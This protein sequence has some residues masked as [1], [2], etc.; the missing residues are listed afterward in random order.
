MR[1][2]LSI[3]SFIIVL[4]LLRLA[5]R[6]LIKKEVVHPLYYV[7][8]IIALLSLLWSA[9]YGVMYAT[10]IKEIAS[11]AYK[12]GAIGWTFGLSVW[13]IF[14]V[15]LYNSTQKKKRNI[16]SYI[17]V[18]SIGFLFWLTA[19]DGKIFASDFK[20]VAWWGWEEI[21]SK[22]VLWIYLFG[23]FFAVTFIFCVV[24]V[25]KTIRRITSR[26]QTRLLKLIVF[27]FILIAIPAVAIN[28]IVPFYDPLI[29]PPVA[30]LIVNGFIL[31]LGRVLLEN[32]IVDINPMIAAPQMFFDI[33]DYVILTDIDGH[34]K[35]M[36][37][38]AGTILNYTQKDFERLDVS[39]IIP[40]LSIEDI[41]LMGGGTGPAF[42]TDV[43]SANKVSIPVRCKIT[44]V[45]DR[46][47]D[48]I[49]YLIIMSD[50]RD[51][52]TIEDLE[53]AVE[54]RTSE[55]A[56]KNRILSLEIAGREKIQN[57]LTQA[58][59][60]LK[61]MIAN[62]S[63][64][65]AIIDEDG[66]LIY[67][68]PNI[69]TF[70]GWNP[71]A[72]I[73]SKVL[74]AINPADLIKIK[75]IFIGLKR[76]PDKTITEVFRLR[77]KDGTYKHVRLTAINKIHNSLIEGILI[78]FYDVS[79]QIALEEESASRIKRIQSHQNA[80]LGIS[81][82]PFVRMGEREEAFRQITEAAAE[83][84]NADKVSIWLFLENGGNAECADLFDR[85]EFS[86]SAG[87]VVA[88]STYKG[89]CGR[90]ENEL[91]DAIEDLTSDER[92]G[93]FRSAAAFTE[94]S[95]AF[96]SAGIRHSG[97]LIGFI[98]FIQKNEPRKWTEDE[99]SFASQLA[100]LV[101]QAVLYG[102]RKAMESKLRLFANTVKSVTE[103][104]SIT[105]MEDRI[106]FVNEFFCRT[107]GYTEEELL[108]KT[109]N[110]L[111]SD[112][113]DVENVSEILPDTLRGKWE[114][115]LWNRKKD[116]TD[117]LIHLSTS[118]IKDESDN[119]VAL[120]GVATDITEKKLEEERL[121]SLLR[122]QSEMIDT[123]AMW[124]NTLDMEG[125]ITFWNKAAEKISGYTKEEVIF[126][127]QIWGM[128]Y[129]D[130]VY[131]NEVFGEAN[132]ILNENKRVEGFYTTIIRKDGEKRIIS[133]YSNSLFDERGNTVGS[134]AIGIDNTE[135]V[136]AEETLR[137]N[138][139][140]YRILLD[141][142]TDPIFSFAQDGTYL[143]ANRAFVSGVGK[144]VSEVIGKRIWDVFE[145]EEADKRYAA[146]K[147]V[148]ETGREKT[149][150][151]RVPLNGEDH[152]YITSITPIKNEAEK[153]TTVIC[154]SKE[155][156]D[157]K[158]TEDALRLSEQKMRLHI[159]ETPLGVI[160]W[161][162]EF[163][164]VSW[165]KA[166][167]RIFGYKAEEALGMNAGLLV[168]E[169]KKEEVRK[170][171]S[172]LIE[173]KINAK[174]EIENIRKDGG[175]I[176]CEW[177]N[178][179][180]TASG[181]DVIGVASLVLDITERQK[182]EEEQKRLFSELK[183]SRAQ[184]EEEAV[185]LALLN[186]QLLESEEKLKE[187]NASKDRFFSIIAHDLKSPFLSLLGYSEILSDEYDTLSE[188]ER[189]ESIAGIYQLSSNSYK[190]LENLLQWARIQIG[191]I[192]FA[193]EKFNLLYE[194]S[195][196]LL[197][198]GQTARDKNIIIDNVIERNTFLTADK[199]MI[200]SIIR[201]L[202]SN[203]IKFCNRGGHIVIS[204]AELDGFTE[205]IIKDN[206]I[207]MDEA[208][209]RNL[210][211][212]DKNIST[213]GTANES[214]T[215][216]GLLLCKEMIEKHGGHI[217]VIS[218]PGKG[219]EFRFAIPKA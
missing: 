20:Y 171:I 53:G 62:I 94:S 127:N 193:P 153:V 11:L 145:K 217:S 209:V 148:F 130:E 118:I 215:G 160:E 199:N 52:I 155:I 143:Y 128:L 138:E 18:L 80:L 183:L 25:I 37:N 113:N 66:T 197:L 26:K 76:E 102:E 177:Y 137:E 169:G 65:I 213:K 45:K 151:V 140:K 91:T 63:D 95:G 144:K 147:T 184:I 124:I 146:V 206:G 210:F 149:I 200:N 180:L 83:A 77:C 10:R 139:E 97:K 100:D 58:D 122:F 55:L 17:V 57:A 157:R 207:G 161:D 22:E 218:E 90:L 67:V 28:M 41:R 27:F 110:I 87:N 185:K 141:E 107:Y 79:E 34:I 174:N 19:L 48:L 39:G 136:K 86:H 175:I 36:S 35:K 2:A 201:N 69:E 176:L 15:E 72:I 85:A 123:A 179:V 205:I 23:A 64:V 194:I 204:S 116:G 12:A 133:W 103:N 92:G 78:N 4:E 46:H 114:G 135:K 173:Q 59:V 106:I 108:G 73:G 99:K 7:L 132:R 61:E 190:L 165:N 112:R 81:S 142:S 101:T 211:N 16:V 30:H 5:Y 75:R 126:R 21:V 74:N 182:A 125:N 167:E 3:I 38:S 60:K 121:F 9:G 219:S 188:E 187:L 158:R 117:F 111:R 31:L 154:S 47:E 93:E 163:R 32:K 115:E 89:F 214:G 51:I 44:P 172:A 8:G 56:E 13:Y 129:P 29:I 203:A 198:L 191:K 181:G 166:A 96:L 120:V 159:E 40:G 170:I 42:K 88:C 202:I 70:F 216:L 6:I 82:N 98:T 50:L 150:E 192:E 119:P 152:F 134:I 164:V 178:T 168:T 33:S 84:I 109:V 68:S 212:I 156:T 14:F 105:D 131:R 43:I 196:T 71:E 162:R 24:F 104:V 195:P 54:K 186:E 189:K 1:T 208:Q 49:G